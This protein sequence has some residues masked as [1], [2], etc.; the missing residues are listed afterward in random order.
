MRV[1]SMRSTGVSSGPPNAAVD[2]LADEE[3]VP[4]AV[5]RLAD[6]QAIHAAAWARIGAPVGPSR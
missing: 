4:A 6:L 5:D 2:D 3:R 1:S